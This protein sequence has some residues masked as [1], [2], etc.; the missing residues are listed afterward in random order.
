CHA[1]VVGG[2]G[3]TFAA[4][5]ATTVK[6]GAPTTLAWHD[7]LGRSVKAAQ[8][9]FD[10]RFVV[11]KTEYDLMGTVQRQ[12]MPRYAD[13]T[14]DQWQ[15]R[16]YDRQGRLVLQIDPATDLAT[17]NG[18]RATKHTYAGRRTT[19]RVQDNTLND[20]T[21]CAAGTACYET[22]SYTNVLGNVMYGLDAGNMATRS[23]IDANG[24]V[25]GVRDNE[26]VL[27]RASFD[28]R[29][30]RTQSIDPDQGLWTYA[31]NG[32]DELVSETDARG[33]V[34]TVTQRD[35]LGRVQQ[36]TRT[37]PTPLPVGM[38]GDV[39][40]DEWAYDPPNG[41]GQIAAIVRKRGASVAGAVQVWKE[42]YGYETTTR[43]P[44]TITSTI[45]GEA[46]TWTSGVTYDSSGREATRSYPSGLVVRT[47]YTAWGQVRQLSNQNSGAIYWTATAT[48]A[49]GKVTA[50]TFGNGLTGTHT[51][52]GSTGQ[53]RQL[54][55]KN[56]AATIERFDYAYDPLGNL[57]TQQRDGVTES[58]GYDARQRLTATSLSSGG[59]VQFA[60]SDAGNLMRKTDFSAGGNAYSYGGNG[61]GPHGATGVAM[62]G[63]GTVTYACDAN[64]NVVGGSALTASFDV[65]NR[66][67]TITRSASGSG[68][69]SNDLIF[70]NGFEPG[71]AVD[72]LQG[73]PTDGSMSYAYDAKGGRY[74]EI[75]ASGTTRYGPNG[76]EKVIAGTATHRHE[77]G[78]VVVSRVG[79]I[80]TVRYVLRD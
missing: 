52:A 1:S 15:V 2:G 30:R 54:Q 25:V 6:A 50:E 80:D 26:G 19:T 20:A 75:A 57:K 35:T 9:G 64:G 24:K 49:W 29:G 76:Y 62:P 21:P 65:E 51:W 18:N 58:Y 33:A 66:P 67:R 61:C 43:R 59:G 72:A 17:G 78:P 7:R 23:W 37:P 27:T 60:Y 13:A 69:G 73:G 31:Y 5:C 42:E 10:G 74:V 45:E 36:T 63:G 34:M 14:T 22:K 41:A 11:T 32:L 71:A 48:D 8:R 4:Y 56:G 28:A 55:W 44:S 16:S 39:L 77:L 53:A 68:G 70:R 38:T 12:S 3:E 40:V 46:A 47:D 79:T